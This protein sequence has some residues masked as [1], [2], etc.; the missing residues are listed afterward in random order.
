MRKRKVRSHSGD[1]LRSRPLP[2]SI[3]IPKVMTLNTLADVRTLMGHLPAETREKST[4][5]QVA[6]CLD[7]AARGPDTVNVYTVLQ[8]VMT[9]EGVEFKLK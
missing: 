4:W 5:L 8:M 2:R 9:M 6:K 7:E 1:L 3:V